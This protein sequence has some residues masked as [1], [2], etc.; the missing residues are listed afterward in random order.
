MKAVAEIGP[1]AAFFM[2]HNSLFSYKSGVYQEPA[3]TDKVNHGVRNYILLL[4]Q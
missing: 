3:C 4:F 2:V 1:I